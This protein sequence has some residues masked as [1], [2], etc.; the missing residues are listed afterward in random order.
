MLQ[1]L[2]VSVQVEFIDSKRLWSERGSEE[3]WI[4]VDEWNV[5][6]KVE[7]IVDRVYLERVRCQCRI[8]NKEETKLRYTSS[9]FPAS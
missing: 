6:L 4:R 5:L 9:F 7:V 3:N 1:L 8:S 2:Q